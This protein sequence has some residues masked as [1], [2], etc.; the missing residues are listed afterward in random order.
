MSL[1]NSF[2]NQIGREL[3][4]DAYRSVISGASRGARK[5]QIVNSDEPIYNQVINFELL[6]NDEKT[7]KHLTNLVEKAENT[8]PEDFEWQELF[9]ELDNKIDFC[10]AHLSEEYL[11]QLEKLDQINA[12]NYKWI[13]GKHLKYIDTVISHFD[14][15]ETK[16]SQ[17][18]IGLAYLLTL[19]GL[20]AS[21]LGE[22]LIYTV[23]NVLYVFLLGFTFFNGLMTYNDPKAFNGNLPTDTEK[24]IATIESTGLMLM[25]IALFF[26]LLYFRLG[27]YKISKYKKEIQKNI[28]SKHKFEAYKAELLQ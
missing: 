16:L 5:Q 22:Q 6:A 9:Y 13:K 25:G 15:I 28:E 18:N 3:G 23:I 19:I 4:R 8:D 27:A 12:E 17:K 20:R 26:Y 2:I 21:Y 24:E 7:Y 1:V 11:P 14:T 10:K